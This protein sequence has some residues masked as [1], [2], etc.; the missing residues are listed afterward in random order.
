MRL[1]K[2]AAEAGVSLPEG[3]DAQVTGFAIDNRKVA[4]G[5]VFGAFQ[6]AQ[7]NG[8]DFIPA[9]I[10]AGAVAVIARPRAEVDGAIHIAS[11]TPRKCFAEIA[12]R[13][14]TP[15]PQTIVAVTGTNGKTST[16]EMTRQLWRMAGH[17]AASI[18]TLG[19][20]TPDES[21]STGLTTPDI[22]TFLSN[23]SGLAREGVS[24]V[25]YEA[26]SHGL[27]QYR[28][29][30]LPV[31]AAGFTNLSRDH[32]D[33]HSDMDDYFAAKMR[34]FDEVVSEDATVVVWTG[35]SE[36]AG[37]AIEHAR[38]RQLR[39]LTVGEQVDGDHGGI[40]LLAHTPTQLGQELTI[41]YEGQQRVIRLPL[42][43]AY[44]TANALVAAGLVIATGGDPSMTFDA[45]SRLQPVRGRLERAAITPSGA[46]VYIDYAHTPDALEAA[47][48]ALRPHVSGRLFC[49]FGA[50][51]DR[52]HGKRAPM[53]AAASRHADVVI[54]TDDNPRGEDAGDIRREVLSGAGDN[55]IEIGD[56]REAIAHA[57]GQAEKDDIVLVAGKGHEEGQIIG[58]GADM[59]VLPFNDVEV[60]REC[61][62]QRGRQGE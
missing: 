61:A 44:Q 55:A 32:L 41:E 9:A 13:F 3:A 57:I 5:T 30:G 24:H 7:V 48:G 62:S 56:R 51:G 42:I 23:M 21:V 31:A 16:V 29:E 39:V 10:E 2:L 37:R 8:E 53:G 19:V 4:P 6:G 43:G 45:V 46:P 22:V 18:G 38:K 11:D 14:F 34:L 36:W 12:A 20:T 28:N 26:S 52:D 59:R 15:V 1:A 60:A 47:I 33:Y 40:R 58:S 27:S 17:R 49:V 35:N 25:A 50:G 54:V